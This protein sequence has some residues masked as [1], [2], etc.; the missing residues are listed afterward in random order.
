MKEINEKYWLKYYHTTLHTATI[1]NT[2]VYS[3]AIR[4]A[5]ETS[6]LLNM[7]LFN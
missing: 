3:L 1:R 4:L 2:K 5:K 6:E 7:C